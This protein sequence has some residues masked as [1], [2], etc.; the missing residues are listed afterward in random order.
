MSASHPGHQGTALLRLAGLPVRLWLAGSCPRL[1]TLLAE[2][3]RSATDYRAA[4]GRLAERIGEHLVPRPELTDRDRARLLDLRRALHNGHP[5]DAR[6]CAAVAGLVADLPEPAPEIAGELGSLA[7]RARWL[8]ALDAHIESE[9]A[10]ERARLRG[11]PWRLLRSSPAGA[12]TLAHDAAEVVADIESRLAAGEDW[13]AKRLRQRGDYLWRLIGRGAVKTTP[14]SWLGQVAVL[15]VTGSTGST[16]SAGPVGPPAGG[17]RPA[18]AAGATSPGDD[19]LL[20]GVDGQP[21]TAH[22]YAVHQVSNVHTARERLAADRPDRGPERAGRTARAEVTL[23]GLHWPDGDDLVWWVVDPAD[24]NRMRE[25]RLRATPALRAVRRVLAQGPLPVADLLERL[26][27]PGADGPGPRAA[28]AGFLDHLAELG[29]VQGTAEVSDHLSDWRHTPTL[30]STQDGPAFVDVYRQVRAVVSAPAVER[31]RAATGQALRLAA[32]IDQE[33]RDRRHPAL[34]LVDDRPRTVP[35]LVR[36]FL[37]EHGDTPGPD[38]RWP[39]W[40]TAD[41]P[42][43]GYARL[44]AWLADRCDRGED[45]IRLDEGLWDAV[46]APEVDEDW[47]LDVLL[48]PLAR[49]GPLA[50]LETAAAPAATDAR[51]AH[52]LTRLHGEPSSVRDYR[53]FLRELERRDG[54][55][56]VEVLVPPMTERAANAVRRPRYTDLWTGDPD[57]RPYHAP[58]GS[59]EG[60]H[61]YVPL[62]EITLRRVDDR[63][64]A[65]ADGRVLWPMYHAT[66]VPLPPWDVVVTLL[67]AAAPEGAR[68]GCRWSR[69]LAAFPTRDHLPRV[70]IGDDLVLCPA[71]WR[72]RRSELW[73]PGASLGDR[74]RVLSGL[75][76]RRGVPRWVFATRDGHT[77]PVPVDLA[78]LPAVRALDRLL[79]APDT[80]GLVVEE[81]LPTPE[82]FLVTDTAHAPGDRLAAQLLLRLPVGVTPAELAA[83]ASRRTPATEPAAGA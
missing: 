15:P 77:R 56:F 41:R 52:G 39:G 16:G 14:R 68:R 3:D 19:A 5:V 17:G 37:D 72:L 4:A 78:G 62:H 24:R 49:G 22:R 82:Q 81:M 2:A 10:G 70:Q 27:G 48:R 67:C 36:R 9:I 71:Q 43:S 32:L 47:P 50:V 53:A 42:D 75:M 46:G 64:V 38:H 31:V 7:E 44:L 74:L 1:F 58:G 45:P 35:D 54:G 59:W 69:P 28:L 20:S 8:R 66:R 11:L 63:V 55:R 73:A 34:A 33:R 40:P 60:G 30:E 13:E 6:R 79:A 18:G 25:V 12:A 23:T 26:L 80:A 61:E 65:E 29:V 21:P 76:R 51:F 57:H 83:R